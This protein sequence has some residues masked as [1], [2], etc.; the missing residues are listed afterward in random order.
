MVGNQVQDLGQHFL[1]PGFLEDWCGVLLHPLPE[2]RFE[3][4]YVVL[5]KQKNFLVGGVGGDCWNLFLFDGV[6]W[7]INPSSHLLPFLHRDRLPNLDGVC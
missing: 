7:G 5:C 1:E 6:G 4:G 3:S 2:L